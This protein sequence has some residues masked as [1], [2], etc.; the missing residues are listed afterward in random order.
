MPAKSRLSPRP[1][2][3]GRK[4]P[5]RRT[6]LP[7][8]PPVWPSTDRSGGVGPEIRRGGGWAAAAVVRQR[9]N[10]DDLG[11]FDTGAVNGADRRFAAGAGTLHVNLDLAQAQVVGY[12]RAVRSGGLSSIGSILLGTTET[13]LTA[14]L[15]LITWPSAFAIV[16][17]TLLKVEC[18]NT[19]PSV[20]TLTTLFLTVPVFF[21]ITLYDYFV[22]FFLLA[23]VFLRPLRVRALFFVL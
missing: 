22:A 12:L 20:P 5:E 4:P 19:F 23:T 18:T 3:T 16:M 10:V 6:P 17:I 2:V 7:E 14:E 13:H 1:A 9:S 8:T 21:A 15:Q 11:H